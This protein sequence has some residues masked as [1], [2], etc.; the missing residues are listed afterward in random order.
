M[1]DFNIDVQINAGLGA[2]PRYKKAQNTIQIAEFRKS[3]GI[4]TDWKAVA[5]QLNVL[6]GFAANQFDAPPPAPPPPEVDYKAN[7]NIDLAQLPPQAQMILLQK[8]MNGQMNLT[9]KIDGKNPQ[10]QK[11]IKESE[12]N[13][14]GLTL[15]E[16]AGS[17]APDMTGNLGAQMSAGGQQN[18]Q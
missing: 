11:S 4:P 8:M 13:G 5:A 2:T 12:Q 18:G 7:I 17:T 15:P 16:R 1:F 6:A 9:A 3:M 10:M 14:S